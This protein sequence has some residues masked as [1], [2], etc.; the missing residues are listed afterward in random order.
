MIGIAAFS[1]NNTSL[2][3]GLERLLCYPMQGA[4]LHLF[5]SQLSAGMASASSTFEQDQELFTDTILKLQ[6][7]SAFV[8]ESLQN[9]RSSLP[10]LAQSCSLLDNL[11]ARSPHW[12]SAQ[13]N[14][15]TSL[16]IDAWAALA[17][18]CIKARDLIQAEASL[19]RLSLLQDAVAGPLSL[20]SK[21]N[22]QR[23][24]RHTS[25]PA[26]NVSAATAHHHGAG[27]SSE[28]PIATTSATIDITKEQCQAATAL[29]QIWDK[30]R[31]VYEDM[32]QQEMANNFAKRIVKMKERLHDLQLEPE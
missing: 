22:K 4:D 10:L 11:P 23:R 19:Q 20:R 14:L 26:S 30:L 6:L 7:H 3:C 21:T 24:A 1:K 12:T 25:A 15:I 28:P 9:N 17:D 8:K 27:L 13:L 18:E 16:K 2:D 5:L 29:I 31:Q 32:G